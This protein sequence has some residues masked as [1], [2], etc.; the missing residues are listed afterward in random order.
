MA[1]KLQWVLLFASILIAYL[2]YNWKDHQETVAIT[3]LI[4]QFHEALESSP[5]RQPLKIGAFLCI[6]TLELKTWQQLD[7][8]PI[9][10]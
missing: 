8:I 9:W 7:T 2:V 10:I 3:D 6:L 5:V 4:S 1:S